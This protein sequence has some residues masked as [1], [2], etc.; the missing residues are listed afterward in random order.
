MSKINF[1]LVATVRALTNAALHTCKRALEDTKGNVQAAVEMVKK[2]GYTVSEKK[3]DRATSEGCIIGQVYETTEGVYRGGLLECQSETDFVST[4]E[5]FIDFARK[6]L[7]VALQAGVK[8]LEGLLE[9]SF[10][11]TQ[12][13]EQ[14]RKAL[15]GQMGENIRISRYQLLETK[16]NFGLYVHKGRYGCIVALKGANPNLAKDI[17]VH[18]VVSHPSS[19]AELLQQEFYKD[20]TKSI[21]AYLKDSQAEIIDYAYFVLGVA[22]NV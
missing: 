18:V 1:K 17:A 2:M 8:T 4:N 21:E 20:P 10:D 3:A 11:Q 6:A 9:L 16:E 19:L 14:A 7:D 15:V 22:D 5:T 12:T 13:V